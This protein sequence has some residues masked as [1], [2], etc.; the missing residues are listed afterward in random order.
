MSNVVFFQNEVIRT[1][2]SQSKQK[3]CLN[4]ETGEQRNLQILKHSLECEK[5]R[6]NVDENECKFKAQKINAIVSRVNLGSPMILKK[7]H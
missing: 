4:D 1:F 2:S 6:I 3:R 7:K 5:K